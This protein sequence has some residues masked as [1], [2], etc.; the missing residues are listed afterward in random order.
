M[1]G[2]LGS[3]VTY[4]VTSRQITAA[5]AEGE[6]QRTHDSDQ[7]KLDRVHEFELAAKDRSYQRRADTYMAVVKHL[8]WCM[9]YAEWRKR[10]LNAW[11]G[12]KK[13]EVPKRPASLDADIASAE[14]MADLFL[15]EK[16]ELKVHAVNTQ[17]EMMELAIDE[18]TNSSGGPITAS[19]NR[20]LWMRHLNEGATYLPV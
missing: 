8:R 17:V 9:V 18:V 13:P 19:Y 1:G 10:T 7:R 6:L 20:N 12:D 3:L 4:Q 11:L 2:G 14:A 16:A 15:P 5:K